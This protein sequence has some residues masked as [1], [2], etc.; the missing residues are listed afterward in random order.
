M[1]LLHG[2]LA[3]A[4][5]SN[6]L[7]LAVILER[8]CKKLGVGGGTPVDQHCHRQI[9]LVGVAGQQDLRLGAAAVGG[10]DD[11]TFRQQNVENFS[12]RVNRP[13]R[14]IAHVEYKGFRSP[15][16]QLVERLSE[17]IGGGVVELGNPQVA[18]VSDHPAAH[19]RNLH[20]AAGDGVAFVNAVA[21]HQQGDGGARLPFESVGRAFVVFCGD[22]QLV[23]FDN[24]IPGRKLRKGGGG[25]LIDLVDPDVSVRALAAYD[26]DVNHPPGE[27][28]LSFG[29]LLGGQVGRVGVLNSLHITADQILAQH[30]LVDWVIILLANE[31][32]DLFDLGIHRFPFPDVENG[33]VERL[34]GI[35]P[36]RDEGNG[37]EHEGEGNGRAYGDFS[38][39]RKLLCGY[40]YR[41]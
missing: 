13:A 23:N 34:G 40:S 22:V 31:I 5:H 38:V 16:E 9:D 28:A 12:D 14:I 36:G 20:L 26:A 2:A 17:L 30:I 24:Q 27:I 21:A 39:H 8:L 41:R 19:C 35:D 25:I 32:I 3:V 37:G 33:A 4:G 10:R 15:A 29:V 11:R 6:G 18:R 1:H 7:G